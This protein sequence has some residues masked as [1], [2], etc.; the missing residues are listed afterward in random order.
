MVDELRELLRAA[1]DDQRR[2]EFAAAEVKYRAIVAARPELWDAAYLHGTALM[3]LGRFAEAIEVFR[4]LVQVR[5]DLP[6]VQNNLG[7]AYQ[8]L[9]DWD[10]A[11]VAYQA[12]LNLR[13][14]FDRAC[15]NLGRLAEQRGLFADAENWY[16]RAAELKPADANYW[17]HLAGALGKQNKWD[18]AERVLRQTVEADPE[19]LDHRVNLAYALIQRERLEEAAEI[20]QH[21]LARRPDYHE[22]HSNLAFVRERQGR[23]D[24]ALAAAQRAIELRPDYAEA[25]NN[26]GMILRSLHRLDEACRAFR[27]ALERQPDFALGEFNL[28]TTL[29]L[30]GDYAAGWSGYR[31]HGRIGGTAAAAPGLPEWDGRPIPGKR[32]LVYADQGFGDTIQFARFLPLCRD[33]SEARIVFSCQPPLLGLFAG[34][35]GVDELLG[36]GT[37]GPECDIQVALASLPRLLGVTIESAA[38]G[39]PYLRPPSELR[40]ELADRLRRGPADALRVGLVWQGNRQQTR[41]VVRSCPLEKLLPLLKSEAAT[42]FSLQTEEIGRRSIA[43]LHLEERLIDLG[44]AL[45]DFRETAAVV[46]RLDLVITVDTGTA[47]L[48]GALGRPVW[49]MLCHTPDWRWHLSRRDSPWYPT[50]RLFRQPRWGD[51]D[52]V[53]AEIQNCFWQSPLPRNKS[54]QCVTPSKSAD[55][56]F[57]GTVERTR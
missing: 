55:H 2:G 49:T 22:V 45:R 21:V 40:P 27:N 16:R 10:R 51:W 4:R 30:A 52:S 38:T 43:E 50:M 31:Q 34:L 9:G 35:A 54:G 17:F 48:A 39:G 28:G 36:R 11:A 18:E 41:D 47:H 44:V 29:L 57:P 24:E 26:L 6:D 56:S 12:A 53:V 13:G 1:M 42:F 37:P 33:Q 20:Y 32:L 23:F 15:F 19:N 8:A 5:P 25:F 14:D 7:V 46:E 3:Q